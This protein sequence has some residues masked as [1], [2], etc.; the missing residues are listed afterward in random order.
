MNPNC[1]GTEMNEWGKGKPMTLN[2]NAKLFI[3]ISG[4]QESHN[5][6]GVVHNYG[7]PVLS[8]NTLTSKRCPGLCL[9]AV[10]PTKLELLHFIDL[11]G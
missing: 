7:S 5:F 3:L 11:S 1:I 2:A 8:G 4:L 10:K 6:L 9:N